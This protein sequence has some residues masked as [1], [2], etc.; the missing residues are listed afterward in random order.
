MALNS[1]RKQAVPWSTGSFFT[2][3]VAAPFFW[4]CVALLAASVPEEVPDSRS[5]G[6]ALLECTRRCDYSYACP[7]S[8]CR[9]S[10]PCCWSMIGFS[11][12]WPRHSFAMTRR[13]SL[14]C[15]TLGRRAAIVVPDTAHGV[16]LTEHF[17][18]PGTCVDLLR[19]SLIA[20]PGQPFDFSV[21]CYGATRQWFLDHALGA[22]SCENPR[23]TTDLF[24][25][26][27]GRS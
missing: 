1:R 25:P 15:I 26:R 7:R 9:T 22:K 18:V 19:E 6:T 12:C 3:C 14:F 11:C 8:W 27:S 4:F 2:H 13:D 21:L 17:L 20:S 16:S 24:Q 10:W 23:C 5:L